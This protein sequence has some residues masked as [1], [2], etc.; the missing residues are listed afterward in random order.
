[1]LNKA[2]EFGIQTVLIL[3]DF[4]T[5]I[6]DASW[7]KEDRNILG[8]KEIKDNLS[9]IKEQLQKLCPNSEIVLNSSFYEEFSIETISEL[10][11][12]FKLSTLLSK[13]FLSCRLSQDSL[14]LR[15][16]FYPVLQSYDFYNLVKNKN[17]AIQMGGQD[18]WGNITTGIEFIKKKESN[19][20]VGGF[21]IPLLTDSNGVKFGKS[22]KNTLFLNEK[23]TSP[24]KVYQYFWNLSDDKLK[25]L[26][27]FLFNS[28]LNVGEKINQKEK[29]KI[30]ENLFCGVYS[31]EKF[32][33]IKKIS[34]FLFSKEEIKN[35][36]FTETDYKELFK[37]LPSYQSKELNNISNILINLGFSSSHSES[38]RLIEKERCVSCFSYY[39]QNHKE[40]LKPELSNSSYFLIKKGEKEFGI[41]HLSNKN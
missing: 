12:H 11:K 36:S 35:N 3:G 39:F 17:I 37:I 26:S 25:E 29:E 34:S 14:T 32:Q 40:M 6:G 21:T 22:G 5:K 24:Y 16:V 33:V 15:D 41:F 13:D 1:M 23:L 38:K 30:I 8:E 18:Q 28:E 27:I 9:G 7:R 19:L 20:L 4:T 10:L 31:K 2:S